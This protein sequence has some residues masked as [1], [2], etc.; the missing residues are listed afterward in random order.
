[1]P[2]SNDHLRAYIR[3]RLN[4]NL[5]LPEFNDSYLDALVR[6]LKEEKANSE[7]AK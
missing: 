1:M 2:L 7:V 4:D 5:P 6:V 3:A